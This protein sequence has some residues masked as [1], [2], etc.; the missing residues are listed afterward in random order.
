MAVYY[1]NLNQ[2]TLYCSSKILCHLAFI[3][4]PVSLM[5][6]KIIHELR[7]GKGREFREWVG[8]FPG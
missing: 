6:R 8:I 2:D 5:E 1:N 4:F 3:V 7:Q